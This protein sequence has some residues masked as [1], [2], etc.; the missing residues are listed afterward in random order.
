MSTRHCVLSLRQRLLALLMMCA[1][2]VC[3]ASPAGADEPYGRTCLVVV[4]ESST[5]D[6]PGVTTTAFDESSSLPFEEFHWK[7]REGSQRRISRPAATA[8]ALMAAL[9]PSLF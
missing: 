9:T 1:G 6:P 2:L 8:R 5:D 4:E 7:S 3:T